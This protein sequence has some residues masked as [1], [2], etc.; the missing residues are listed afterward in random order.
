MKTNEIKIQN[1]RVCHL[2]EPLGFAMEKPVFSWTAEGE[3][4]EALAYTLR[5]RAGGKTVFESGETPRAD[6]LGWPV[7]LE[8]LPRTRYDYTLSLETSDGQHA[9]ASSFFETGKR[10]EP[11][12]GRW[13]SPARD[14]SSALLRKRFGSRPQE[15]AQAI[16]RGVL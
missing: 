3:G 12:T 10:E 13:I 14:R 8:L 9:E 11:W 6:S 5:I 16:L 1:L 7:P 4:G 2:T 15:D